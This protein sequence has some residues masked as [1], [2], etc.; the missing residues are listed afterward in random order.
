M[1]KIQLHEKFP[2]FMTYYKIVHPNANQLQSKL[3]HKEASLK[4]GQVN[5]Y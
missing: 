4:Y 5:I 3:N 2:R 1:S